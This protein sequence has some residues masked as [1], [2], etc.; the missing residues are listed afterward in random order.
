M[1]ARRLS[2]NFPGNFSPE[3]VG[4]FALPLNLVLVLLL[5]HSLAKLTWSLIPSPPAASAGSATSLEFS[6][7]SSDTESIDYS[8]IASWHLFGDSNAASAP[9]PKPKAA[10]ET[11]LK[12]TLAGLFYSANAS[13]ALA[14]IAEAGGE[15]LIYRIGDLL[16]P[17]VR[18]AEIHQD[19]VILSRNGR[20]ETLSLPQ[21]NSRR[22][23]APLRRSP[24]AAPERTVD[25]GPI[26]QSLQGSSQG[27]SPDLQDLAFATPFAQD[28][29]FMG[30]RLEPGKKPE[31][32]GRLGLQNGDVLVE[33]NGSRLDS[34][35]QAAALLGE[36]LTSTDQINVMVLRD[37]AEV[38]IT[39][40]LS[41]S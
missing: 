28:G 25:A 39:F 22:V 17:K 8:A 23:S 19:R 24:E 13:S 7:G 3:S 5:S 27:A 26:A 38:P 21:D 33:I 18:L 6:V 16:A 1:L 30:L 15:A 32:L 34:P 9:I 4:Y 2:G 31:L 35:G 36:I 41:G 10:P 11:R 40:L 12:L 29:Q 37:G 14:I 20:L